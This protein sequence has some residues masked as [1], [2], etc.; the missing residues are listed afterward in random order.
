MNNKVY[1][2]FEQDRKEAIEGLQNKKKGCV[3]AAEKVVKFGKRNKV[4]KPEIMLLQNY[5]AVHKQKYS[6]EYW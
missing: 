2:K 5:I 4:Y 3:K 6:K 1:E